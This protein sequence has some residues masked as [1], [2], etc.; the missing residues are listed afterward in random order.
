MLGVRLNRPATVGPMVRPQ[1]GRPAFGITRRSTP[2]ISAGTTSLSGKKYRDVVKKNPNM[3][4]VVDDL[5]AVNTLQA[6]RVEPRVAQLRQNGKPEAN[7]GFDPRCSGHFRR[8]MNGACT[9]S[10]PFKGRTAMRTLWNRG[11]QP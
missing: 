1:W 2:S 8:I 7:P 6:R 3:A 9:N 5:A 4:F 11:G 10:W